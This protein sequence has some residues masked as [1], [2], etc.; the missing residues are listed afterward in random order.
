MPQS[1]GPRFFVR[2]HENTA[3]F[4]LQ[5]NEAPNQLGFVKGFSPEQWVLGKRPRLPLS[6]LEDPGNLVGHQEVLEN[7]GGEFATM[8]R[9]SN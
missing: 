5:A 7:P 9:L 8:L 6:V 4:L 2:K 1:D 3:T